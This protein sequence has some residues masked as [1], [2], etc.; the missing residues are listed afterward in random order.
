MKKQVQKIPLDEM[1]LCG[2]LRSNHNDLD[3]GFGKHSS[4]VGKGACPRCDCSRFTWATFC[5]QQ[6]R[7]RMKNKSR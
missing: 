7:N 6:K 3:F 2:H 4:L 5:L 1:C